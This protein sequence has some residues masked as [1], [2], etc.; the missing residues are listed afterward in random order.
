MLVGDGRRIEAQGKELE[1][2]RHVIWFGD[3]GT[4]RRKRWQS[5][6]HSCFGQAARQ[7]TC[8]SWRSRHRSCRQFA[9]FSRSGIAKFVVNVCSPDTNK[10]TNKTDGRSEFLRVSSTRREK[11]RNRT[12]NVSYCYCL[13]FQTGALAG[14]E[15]VV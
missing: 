10:N 8:S 11:I 9:Q 2:A 12:S 6:A 3:A 1:D 5:S 4:R 7:S 15:L 14:V 13:Y